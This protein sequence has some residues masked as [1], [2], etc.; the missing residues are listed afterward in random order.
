VCVK[1]IAPIKIDIEEMLLRLSDQWDI[2][3]LT[4]VMP[5]QWVCR[6]HT[7]EGIG[8]DIRCEAGTPT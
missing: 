3:E 6:D 4:M 5:G 2:V 7:D 8:G 1:Y